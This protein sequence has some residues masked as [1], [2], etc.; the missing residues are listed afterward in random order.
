MAMSNTFS[1]W[2]EE[3]RASRK[4]AGM[5]QTALAAACRCSRQTIMNVEKSRHLP[6]A[7]VIAAL[8]LELKDLPSPFTSGKGDE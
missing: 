1:K 3:V 7:K 8:M 5:S 6:S 4:R 2:G